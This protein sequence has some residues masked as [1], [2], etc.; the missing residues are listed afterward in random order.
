MGVVGS[1]RSPSAAPSPTLRAVRSSLVIVAL[2]LGLASAACSRR[3]VHPDAQFGEL[4][5][6]TDDAGA[7]RDGG[8]DAGRDAA[9]LAD[10]SRD[11]GAA[12]DGG[13]DVGSDA[14]RDAGSSGGG[15]DP[16]LDVPPAGNDPCAMPGSLS[17]CPGIAVC[18]FYSPTEGRCESCTACG[19]LFAACSSGEE[20][21][22]LFVCYQGQCTN[23]C[24]LGT[25]ECGA[26]SDCIDIGHPTRGACRPH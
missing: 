16:Q 5:L 1:E 25:S 8:A 10:G 14:G 11:T 18:R 9:S 12:H 4:D 7:L 6:G 23:F 15:L 20:C 21:D 24:T 2:A 22:I 26:P 19:N 13:R 17:E 3:G